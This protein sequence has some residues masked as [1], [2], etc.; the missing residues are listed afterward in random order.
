LRSTNRAVD[1]PTTGAR[2]TFSIRGRQ[3]NQETIINLETRERGSSRSRRGKGWTDE[4]YY[5]T[6]KKGEKKTRKRIQLG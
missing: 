1:C 3:D 5:M 6:S 4:R 2:M